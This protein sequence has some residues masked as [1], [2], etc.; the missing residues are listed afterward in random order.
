MNEIDYIAFNLTSNLVSSRLA[1]FMIDNKRF[2]DDYFQTE[3]LNSTLM[4]NNVGLIENTHVFFTVN[5]GDK[6]YI[7]FVVLDKNPL[8]EL[9]KVNNEFGNDT[10]Y[11]VLF[12]KENFNS[13]D[14]E[15]LEKNLNRKFE[16]KFNS[17]SFNFLNGRF[18]VLFYSQCE[19]TISESIKSNK[20][21]KISLPRGSYLKIIKGIKNWLET[22]G[23]VTFLE[24]M[25]KFELEVKDELINLKDTSI[26]VKEELKIFRQEYGTGAKRSQILL[27]TVNEKNRVHFRSNIT[28]E[29]DT[30]YYL[31]TNDIETNINDR[32]ISAFN[33]HDKKL[34]EIEVYYEKGKEPIKVKDF[35]DRYLM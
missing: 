29:Y 5:N 25:E 26:D 19:T 21:K 24:L 10:S 22:H 17:K 32:K 4:F 28:P 35:K 14:L 13:T 15:K 2:N 8:S 6:R 33:P 7:E 18:C 1:S 12:I 23:Q 9:E 31:D 20:R 16:T 34:S 27:H 11:F 30:F 3:I